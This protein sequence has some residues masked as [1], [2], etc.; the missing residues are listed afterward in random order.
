MSDIQPKKSPTRFS[1]DPKFRKVV[2]IDISPTLIAA[3]NVKAANALRCKD[4]EFV[5]ADAT[6]YEIPDET[7][8]ICFA[9]P[10]AG[11]A[12]EKV[13]ESIKTSVKRRPRIVRLICISASIIVCRANALSDVAAL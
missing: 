10:L 7:T 12:L 8:F 9:N 2:G 3:A 11:M 4:I 1:E 13:F 5:V 6:C